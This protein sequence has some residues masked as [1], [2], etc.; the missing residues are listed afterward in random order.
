[1]NKLESVQEMWAEFASKLP[2]HVRND[3]A[4]LSIYRSLFHIGAFMAVVAIVEQFDDE[5]STA[6]TCA[7]YL[8]QLET[9]LHRFGEDLLEQS[10]TAKDPV[11]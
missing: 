7:D 2:R 10:A 11:H 4:R 3:A 8:E 5:D 6:E 1:M 9:E